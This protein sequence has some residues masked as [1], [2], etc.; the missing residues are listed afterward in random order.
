[1][2]KGPPKIQV[3]SNFASDKNQVISDGNRERSMLDSM[4]YLDESGKRIE[5][6]AIFLIG[7]LEAMCKI[8]PQAVWISRGSARK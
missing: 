3:L 4:R 2:I 7:K 1:M 8:S 5:T 6:C